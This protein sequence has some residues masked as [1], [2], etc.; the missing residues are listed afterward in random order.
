MF[1]QGY[2]LCVN[3]PAP[4]LSVQVEIA[5]LTTQCWQLSYQLNDP[6]QQIIWPHMHTPLEPT[7][8]DDLWQTTCFELFIQAVGQTEYLELNFSPICHWN[9]YRFD[10]YRQPAQMPPRRDERVRL[11]SLN[12]G[13]NTLVAL[14][15]L[16][17]CF[18]TG[19]ALSLGIS[20]V[21]QDHAGQCS[22]WA[23]QHGGEPDFH[24]ASDWLIQVDV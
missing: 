16:S 23:L 14:V 21:L 10:A 4:E 1:K 11:N 17:D 2:D 8:Q 6:Q 9:A 20:A 19:Q 22:Y 7:R 5:Q 24:R 12:I 3:R 18:V 13:R 15:D